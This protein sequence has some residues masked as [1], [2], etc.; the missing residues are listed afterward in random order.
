MLALKILGKLILAFISFFAFVEIIRGL[1]FLQIPEAVWLAILGFWFVALI[2]LEVVWLWR[3]RKPFPRFLTHLQ[4]AP[5]AI[6]LFS[7]AATLLF[8]AAMIQHSKYR[9][10]SYIYSNVPPEENIELDLHNY[11]FRGMCCE[12]DCGARAWL[13]GETAREGSSSSDAA[14]RARSLRAR[15]LIFDLTLKDIDQAEQ[16]ED[17]TVRK[18]AAHFRKGDL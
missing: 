10:H 16:D 14:V 8:D 2:F 13:Y 5:L 12:G 18:L 9:I 6:L 1:L 17:E 15:M 4:F 3:K 7:V 11:T